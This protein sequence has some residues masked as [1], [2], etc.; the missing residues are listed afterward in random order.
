M[1]IK[2]FTVALGIILTATAINASA[3]KTYTEG[4]LTY[5]VTTAA[6]KTDSKIFFRGD[7]SAQMIVAGPANIKLVTTTKHNYFAVLVDVPVASKKLAAVLTPDE[8]DQAMEE[9]PKLAFTP[10]A[11]T[12][13][14]SGFN[15]KKVTATDPKSGATVELWVTTDITV[16]VNAVTSPF[17][18]A[19]G[20][21]VQ[22]TTTQQGQTATFSLASITEQKVPAGTFSIS[23]DYERI[24]Y[25][26]M[27]AMSG[28]K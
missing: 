14:I 20:F 27:K 12:K 15:C 13:Q 18:G 16:P 2:L 22:F 3:Q 25:D 9:V 5:N 23:K 8:L 1:N 4:L 17:A 19:G 21:P 11:E 7:S 24:T 28:K 10:G 26:E 6:G